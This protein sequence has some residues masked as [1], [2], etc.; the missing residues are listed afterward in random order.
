MKLVLDNSFKDRDLLK[1]ICKPLIRYPAFLSDILRGLRQNN[2]N[3]T[4][5]GMRNAGLDIEECYA[6]FCTF[7]STHYRFHVEQVGKD[8]EIEIT[9]L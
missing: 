8:V 3:I 2:R 6:T 9:K 1:D 4:I 7:T 5:Q